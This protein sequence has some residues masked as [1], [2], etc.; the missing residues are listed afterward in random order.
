[1][2]QI[3][4]NIFV[5]SF[6]GTA[7]ANDWIEI[8]GVQLEEGTVATPFRRNAP[9]IQAELAACQRYYYRMPPSTVNGTRVGIGFQ[10]S[11]T[12]ADIVLYLPVSL[13]V[14]PTSVG[15]SGLI[16]SDNANFNANVSAV[17]IAFTG[18]PQVVMLYM[19]IPSN[20]ATSKPGTVSIAPNTGF[21]ELSAEL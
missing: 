14:P 21:L 10:S 5:S 6:T 4:L 2:T 8:T 11:T 20:G 17:T 1:V 3:L 18:T 12:M 19:T 16:Y 13:R 15:F 7:G 9:S